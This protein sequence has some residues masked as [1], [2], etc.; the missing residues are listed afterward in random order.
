[1]ADFTFDD[2]AH[3]MR[4]MG[5]GGSAAEIDE[6]VPRGRGGAVDYLLNF[7]SIDN[8]A[9]EQLIARSF[10]FSDPDNFERFNPDELRRWWF[11][12]MVHTRRQF[13]EKITLFWHNFFA[14]A[15][16]KVPE[17]LMYV[18]NLMLRANAL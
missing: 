11:T 5:F 9:M 8:E 16:S 10:D 2:A 1:M 4:R 15:N 3:L 18:Q 13:Q 7:D 14:T 17:R 12:R 6:L